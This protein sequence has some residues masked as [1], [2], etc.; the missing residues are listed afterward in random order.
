MSDWPAYDRA[1]EVAESSMSDMSDKSIDDVSG[2]SVETKE[3]SVDL[4][5]DQI[6]E[7]D[8][9]FPVT[10]NENAEQSLSASRMA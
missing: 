6:R 2:A 8:Q 7:D 4:V 10:P 5:E 3:E 9:A 1:A